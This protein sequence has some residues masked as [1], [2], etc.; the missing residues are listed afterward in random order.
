MGRHTS[1]EK[2]LRKSIKWLE[3]LSMTEK[4][5]LGI[6]EV[7]RHHYTPGFL[8]AT[9]EVAGGVALN[10]YGGNGIMKMFVKVKKENV[11]AFLEAV[12]DRYAR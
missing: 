2:E 5:I 11:D 8:R 7:A 4:I 3:S 12:K 10:A 6:Y 9:R 1:V